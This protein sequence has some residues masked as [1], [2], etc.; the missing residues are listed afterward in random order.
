LRQIGW[1]SGKLEFNFGRDG[2]LPA[3]NCDLSEN[4][5]RQPMI[6]YLW[7]P[8]PHA[9]RRFWC[10]VGASAMLQFRALGAL[11]KSP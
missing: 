8:S 5:G 4:T 11:L 6:R 10:K 7:H 9:A 3:L 1:P 2:N